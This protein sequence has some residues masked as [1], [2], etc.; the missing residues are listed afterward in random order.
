MKTDRTGRCRPAKSR[1]RHAAAHRRPRFHGEP[2]RPLRPHVLRNPGSFDLLRRRPELVPGA[3]EE[4]LRLQSSVQF[5]PTR[6][7]LADIE[8]AGTT[9]PKDSPIFLLYASGNRDETLPQS[10]NVGSRTQ[11]QPARRLGQRHPLCFGGPLARIESTSRSKL[12]FTCWR[13]R[14]LWSIHR[15]TARSDPSGPRPAASARRLRRDQT[16]GR[17]VMKTF[18]FVACGPLG[19]LR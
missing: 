15:L 11:G 3:I 10:D 14:G 13:T 8:I 4:V 18:Q 9:I 16:R 6:T 7:A 17:A 5:F 1:Q 19:L 12:S 2:D